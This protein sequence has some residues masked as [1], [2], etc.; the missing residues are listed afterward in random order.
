MLIR[1]QCRLGRSLAWLKPRRRPRKKTQVALQSPRRAA[2]TAK[3]TI[4]RKVDA[5]ASA[6][7][8]HTHTHTPSHLLGLRHHKFDLFLA[9][10]PFL[11]TKRKKKKSLYPLK[12]RNFSTPPPSLHPSPLSQSSLA[13]NRRRGR[14]RRRL[15]FLQS[16]N[17]LL[18]SPLSTL[19]F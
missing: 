5:N 17:P 16:L 18:P 11:K 8:S 6:L 2:F 19:W 13:W 7:P 9:S 3:A 10:T 1:F 15:S 12:E 4:F 14:R